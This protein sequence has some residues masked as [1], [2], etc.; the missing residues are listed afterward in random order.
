[1]TAVAGI[2]PGVAGGIA[3]LST[4]GTPIFVQGFKGTMTEEDLLVL[5]SAAA[6]ICAAF[7]AKWIDAFSDDLTLDGACSGP[8][9][10]RGST[11]S[12]L[13]DLEYAG[14]HSLGLELFIDVPF[15]PEAVTVGP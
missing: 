6:D 4:D 13:V 12:T 10:L 8:I 14:L 7:L 5:V 11:P 1:M 9:I 2:D 15:G 3:V